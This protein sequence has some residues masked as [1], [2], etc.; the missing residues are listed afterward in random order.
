MVKYRK[1]KKEDSMNFKWLHRIIVISIL[2]LFIISLGGCLKPV[3]VSTITG[4]VVDLSGNPIEGATIT[5]TTSSSN[6]S[7]LTA[8][9]DEDGKYNITDVPMGFIIIKAEKTGFLSQ[10]ET[11]KIDTE[12]YTQNFM[13]IPENSGVTGTF[14][15]YA[16]QDQTVNTGTPVQFSAT[17][18]NAVGIVVYK[19]DFQSDGT[20]DAQGQNVTYTYTTPGTYTVTLQGIDSQGHIATDTLL[21]NVVSST[22]TNQPPTV[23]I[24]TD[25]NINSGTAPLTVKFLSHAEDPDGNIVAYIW[26]FGDGTTSSEQ[27]PTH[28][29]AQAGTYNVTLIVTDNQGATAMGSLT[30][31]VAEAQ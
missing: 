11:V 14:I 3:K 25:G 15:V 6:S 1:N 23:W 17:A 20:Y 19:W 27:F 16:G 10:T 8:T 5:I 24:A 12:T 13:L 2:L 28:T 26:N 31:T 21:V 30:I 29:Y 4:K 9:T 18:T 7:T 22:P